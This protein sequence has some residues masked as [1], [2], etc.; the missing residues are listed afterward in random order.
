MVCGRDAYATEGSAAGHVADRAGASLSV[1]AGRIIVGFPPG[2]SV[3]IFAR[4]IGQSLSERLGQQ[5]IIENRPGASSG[6]G[7][8][9]VVRAPADGY[10]LLLASTSNAILAT[11]YD[12]LSYNFIRDVAPAAGI[13]R[14]PGVMAV[15]PSFPAKTVAYFIAYTKANP[16]KTNMALLAMAIPHTCLASCSR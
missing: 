7:T 2:G 11:L 8:E 12:N 15:N 3:S 9:A 16:G 4:L 13:V 5:F 6:L 14:T 1:A 10:T